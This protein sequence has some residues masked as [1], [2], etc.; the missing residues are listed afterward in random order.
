MAV[1]P[2]DDQILA[3]Q[4][5]QD[6]IPAQAQAPVEPVDVNSVFSSFFV[7][8]LASLFHHTSV[9]DLFHFPTCVIGWLMPF[10]SA[11]LLAA[12]AF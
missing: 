9:L 11:S 10:L 4:A 2:E 5:L 7:W 12:Y 3:A 6:V 8:L 1:P